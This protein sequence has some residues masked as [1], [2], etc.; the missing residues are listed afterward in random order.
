MLTEQ[1]TRTKAPVSCRKA[2][3]SVGNG[4]A[5]VTSSL[6]TMRMP[7]H[8][9]RIALLLA[10]AFGLHVCTGSGH[11]LT[12]GIAHNSHHN[13]R[14]LPSHAGNR[15][16]SRARR[17]YNWESPEASLAETQHAQPVTAQQAPPF[18]ATH[19]PPAAH[20]LHAQ[21]VTTALSSPWP[22]VALL[23]TT[24]V[25]AIGSAPRAPGSSRGP[26]LT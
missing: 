1:R 26:P 8:A 24:S 15:I 3:N 12:W 13:Q 14:H 9:V 5:V 2:H 4:I 16:S 17:S 22:V 18:A 23:T 25:I 10:L 11:A 7:S 6:T 19:H 21:V 20:S